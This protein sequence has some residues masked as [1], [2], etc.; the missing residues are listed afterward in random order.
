[1]VPSASGDEGTIPIWGTKGLSTRPRRITLIT[2]SP[3]KE[4]A[5]CHFE[6]WA[7]LEN[8]AAFYLST[9]P[10]NLSIPFSRA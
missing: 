8:Y 1:M 5:P 2:H 10:D 3:L 7:L 9:F 6:I 4:K